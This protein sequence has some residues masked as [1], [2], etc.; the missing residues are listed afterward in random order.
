M[1]EKYIWV[2][3]KEV[4]FYH[5]SNFKC[6]KLITWM[7]LQNCFNFEEELGLT[8]GATTL[9]VGLLAAWSMAKSD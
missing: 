4:H 5:L 1:E 2:N 3:R 7:I 9:Y 6:L 8:A